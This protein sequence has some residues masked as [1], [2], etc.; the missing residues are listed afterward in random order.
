M[1]NLQQ[2][3]TSTTLA[4]TNRERIA[5]LITAIL[6]VIGAGWGAVGLARDGI[7][8][9]GLV[10]FIGQTLI[11]LALLIGI[12][13]RR[14]WAVTL[15]RFFAFCTVAQIIVSPNYPTTARFLTTLVFLACVVTLLWSLKGFRTVRRT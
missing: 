3:A 5:V 12:L 10:V 4:F 1:A 6:G 14:G 7:S 15:V 13:Q 2:A 11:Y 8:A 9:L